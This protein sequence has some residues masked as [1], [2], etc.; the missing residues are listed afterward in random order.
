MTQMT[1]RPDANQLLLTGGKA[2]EAADFGPTPPSTV[3]GRLLSGPTTYHAREFDKANPG[4]G[5]LRYWPDGNPVYGV[6]LDLEIAGVGVRRLYVEK[7]RMTTAIQQAML[8]AGVQKVE[9]GGYLSVVWTGTEV[10]AGALPANTYFAEYTKAENGA[11]PSGNGLL[12]NGGQHA[13]AQWQQGVP[14]A[15]NAPAQAPQ[16]IRPSAV[17]ATSPSAG[18]DPRARPE[19]SPSSA[20]SPRHRHRCSQRRLPPPCATRASRPRDTPSFR[21]DAM[22][23]CVVVLAIALALSLSAEGCDQKSPPH[24]TAGQR[25]KPS[26]KDTEAVDSHGRTLVCMYMKGWSGLHWLIPPD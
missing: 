26:Q 2:P 4:Q 8:R 3:A 19:C 23:R 18:A 6:F 14:G 16:S 7:L 5:P 22:K 25:C 24:H 11:L 10:G 9:G 21:G 13:P 17:R 1:D 20:E 12:M 15:V